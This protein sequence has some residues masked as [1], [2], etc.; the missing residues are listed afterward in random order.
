MAA[1]YKAL[2]RSGLWWQGAGFG[3]FSESITVVNQVHG[4]L[5][6]LGEQSPDVFTQNSDTD[7]LDTGKK[8]DRDQNR[9]IARQIHPKHQGPHNN[10]AGIEEAGKGQQ[11]A[12]ITP[13]SQWQR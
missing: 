4:A 6:D 10:K 9:G 11:K 7:Q 3:F 8:Q 1:S 13:D 12:K 2:S 5:L